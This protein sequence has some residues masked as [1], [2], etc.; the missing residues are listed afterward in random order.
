M[1]NKYLPLFQPL[2]LGNMIV[3][4]RICMAPMGEMFGMGMLGEKAIDYYAERAKGGAGL[5]M[6]GACITTSLFNVG[7]LNNLTDPRNMRNVAFLADAVHAGGAKLCM[8]FTAGTGRNAP[9]NDGNCYSASDDVDWFYVPGLKCTAITVEQIQ[10]IMKDTHECAKQAKAAGVDAIN[11]HA[12]NGYLIDQFITSGWNHRTDEYGGSVENRMRFLLEYI[13]AIRTAV[14][15]EFPIIVRFTIDMCVPGLRQEG[16]TDE[17]LKILAKAPIN[18][19]DVDCGCYESGFQIFPPYYLGDATELYVTDKVRELGIDLP[20]FNAGN[21]TPDTGLKALEEG[22]LD[23]VMLGRAL[24]A[25]PYLPNK[26]LNGQPEEIRP[27]IKCNMGCL[28][29]TLSRGMCC[30]VNA[31][32]G[33]EAR[34]AI[35]KPC[36]KQKVVIVGGGIAGLEA[37]RKAVER[38][39]EAV[40]IEKGDRLGGTARDIATPDWK[41]RFRQ[42]FDWY[43]LQMKKLGVK[44]LLNTTVTAECEE[45]K[46]ADRIFVATGSVPF[47]PGI[48]GI[49]NANVHNVLD[50][51]KNMALAAGENIV[52]CGGGLSGCEIG[53]ELAQAGKK[54]TVVEMREKLAVDAAAFNGWAL[55]TK[56]AMAGVNMLTNTTVKKFASEGVVVEKDGE[57]MV[58]PA[59]SVV[60]AFGI[61]SDEALGFEL[62]KKYP[63][64]VQII[65][66]ANAV[67]CIFDAVHDGYNAAMSLE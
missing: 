36:K 51:H 35:V 14:G 15:P 10:Q 52:V 45:L 55:Q 64:R 40:I 32:V 6:P 60:H 48:E 17:M 9:D 63:G 23:V 25:D 18:A 66:D 39:A 5:I 49:N 27:C 30:A 33:I 28:T 43:E 37:A 22:K 2:K 4:N 62:M 20:I 54:V 31:E 21:H 26:L 34:A 41:Y 56:L 58:L 65:G 16:E 8:E 47:V 50:V 38:G 46:D 53:L 42:L 67:N 29:R 24:I 12:H 59:D 61:R 44:V 7:V 3:K 11:I 1:E 13:D 57:E 19:L